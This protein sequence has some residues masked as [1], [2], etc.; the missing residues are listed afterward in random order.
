MV[1][2]ATALLAVLILSGFAWYQQVAT[3]TVVDGDTLWDLAEDYYDSPWEWRRIWE[4]NR[5]S[6]P[7]PNLIYPD[8]VLSIPGREAT[9]TDVAVQPAARVP[10]P[11]PVTSPVGDR[12]V[13]YQDPSVMASGVIRT[14]ELEYLAVPRDAVY[15]APWLI[16]LEEAPASVGRIEGFAGGLATSETP[17][18]YNRVRLS[19][20]DGSPSVGDQ[21]QAFRVF[22]II[23][24]VGQ[25]VRP[26]GVVTIT[27]I[28]EEGAIGIVT[29]EFHRMQFGD[30]VGPMPGHGLSPGQYPATISEG[31]HAMIMG[32]ADRNVLQN[33]ESIAF[34]D[35]GSDDGITIGDEFDYLNPEAGRGVAEGRLQVVGVK[36]GVASARIVQMDDVVFRQGLV[37]QLV[38]KM[39]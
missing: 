16:G 13:F 9:V 12:T 29:K 32:F 26:T 20:T 21:V 19:F 36:S 24:D 8:Q 15:S 30:L 7:N 3:H 35:V 17:R 11:P 10:P 6:V 23:E 25:V 4:A 33:V 31:G 2:S 18:A 27:D 14:G 38:R 5:D 22:R 28:D 34:L 37:V 1:R 39:R